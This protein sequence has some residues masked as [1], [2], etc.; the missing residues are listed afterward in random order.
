VAFRP[1]QVHAQEHLGPV[2]GFGAARP[3][4]DREERG[5][6]VVV[7]REEERRA[8]APE[9]GVETRGVTFELCLELGVRRLVEQLDG[10]QEVVRATK[11]AL[12]QAELVTERIR[13]AEDLLGV[14]L[15]LPEPGVLGEGVEL[16][17]PRGL[18]G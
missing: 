18:C 13:F 10:G 5:P 12:P 11:Q 9:V 17:D 2:G 14:A 3:G 1:A 8:L 6:L 7:A 16:A 4:T 15:V